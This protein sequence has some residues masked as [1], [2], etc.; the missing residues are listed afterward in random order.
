MA[1]SAPKAIG[2]IRVSTD[3][4]ATEGISLEV[5][6]DRIIHY[7]QQFGLNLIDIYRDEWTGKELSGPASKLPSLA[8]SKRV[9]C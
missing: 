7:C 6:Q 5:Q 4:Q 8:W 9:R 2:Y 1:E 3:E